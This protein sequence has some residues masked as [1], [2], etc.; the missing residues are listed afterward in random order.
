MKPKDQ[1]GW[2]ATRV[3]D[4]SRSAAI[5]K[6]IDKVF[7]ERDVQ[8]ITMSEKAM[9]QSFLGMISAVL[10]AIDIVTVAILVIIVLILGNTIAMAVRER[11]TEY[12]CLRAIGFRASHIAAF[13]VGESVTIGIL[14]GVLGVLIA[15]LFINGLL[16]PAL[17][18]NMGAFFPNFSMP[19]DLALK[20]LLIAAG[21]AVIAAL[22]PARQASKLRVVD[23]LRAV[24]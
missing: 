10:T 3:S 15:Q 23:A 11:T 4:P 8:T 5:A 21:L 19:P 7:D 20:G 9:Q 16:G 1:V 17:E 6:Q 13:V 24:E 12:G 2:I 22:I 18:D 14:G